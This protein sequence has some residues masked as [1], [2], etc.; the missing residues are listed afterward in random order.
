V[1]DQTR[2]DSTTNPDA[3]DPLTPEAMPA[4]P[5]AHSSPLAEG[6]PEPEG[7]IRAERPAPVPHA[8]H[9]VV[10]ICYTARPMPV[11]TDAVKAIREQGGRVVLIGPLV[12]GYEVP[13]EDAD[14]YVQLIHRAVPVYV[15]KANPP[16]RYSAQWASI[17]AR[18]LTRRATVRPAQRLLGA[19]T[20][21]WIA[22]R[23]NRDARKVL[24]RADVI[25]AADAGAVYLAWEAARRNRH[26]A[27]VNGIGPTL[28]HLGLA[29]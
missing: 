14:E 26:A 21:W 4:G 13:A 12:K 28:E 20:L 29:R 10:A 7:M 18:N 23:H 24:D 17:V 11:V 27:V 19:S 25:C 8:D 5:P 6:G 3:A 22:A 16:R 9:Q 2:L 15:D 1:T